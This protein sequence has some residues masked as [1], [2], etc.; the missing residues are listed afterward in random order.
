[1]QVIMLENVDF[2]VIHGQAPDGTDM[3]LLQFDCFCEVPEQQLTVIGD[4]SKQLMAILPAIKL[5]A[6]TRYNIPLPVEIATYMAA[7]LDGRPVVEQVKNQ[8][9]VP[10]R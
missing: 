9:F 6:H 8:I 10:G 2:R 5:E 7:L 1:M 4:P 3:K